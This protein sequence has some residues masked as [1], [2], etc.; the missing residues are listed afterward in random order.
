MGG[1]TVRLLEEMLRKGNPEEVKYQKKHGGDISPLYKGGQDNMVSSI[2]T[3]AAP[4]NGTMQ[5]ISATNHLFVNLHMITLNS[6]VVKHSKVDVGLKQWVLLK[7]T[8]KR[9]LNI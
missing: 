5:L 6:K 3:L 8:M 7:E 1:Q 2:T 4:H 9:M